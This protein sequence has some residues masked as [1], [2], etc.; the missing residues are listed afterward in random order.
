MIKDPI[1]AKLVSDLLLQI[2]GQL[3]ESVAKVKT[4]CSPDESTAYRRRVGRLINSIFEDIL[5][6]IYIL[7]PGLKPP[8]LGM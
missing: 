4:D 7:H 5:E 2:N 6:P 8:G 1:T 3:E